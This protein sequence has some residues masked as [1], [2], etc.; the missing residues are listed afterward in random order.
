VGNQFRSD[1]SSNKGVKV[2]SNSVHSVLKVNLEFFSEGDEFSDTLSPLFDLDN[3]SLRHVLSHRGLG[4][5]DNLGSLLFIEDNSSDFSVDFVLNIFLTLNEVDELGEDDVIVDDFSEFREGPREPLLQSH[6]ESVDILVQLLNKS[7]GLGDRLVLSVNVKGA[8]LTRELMTETQ[9]SFSKVFFR[10]FFDDLGEMS[11]DSTHKFNNSVVERSGDTC[12]IKDF[13][14]ESRVTDS[15]LVLLFLGS[16][17]SGEM[18]SQK[19][20]EGGGNL[21]LH[22]GNDVLK[23]FLSSGEGLVSS[24]S[25]H[26]GESLERV[27]GLLDL[28]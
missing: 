27:N 1:S 23:S 20:F 24:E 7:D 3:I 12:G 21:T 18:G 25:D 8:L 5:L 9:L 16:L 13:F 11:S 6:A 2:R 19:V 22:V 15:E 26:L 4:S 17:G 10:D 28:R 14:T